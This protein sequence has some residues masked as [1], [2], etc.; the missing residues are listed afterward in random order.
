MSENVSLDFLINLKQSSQNVQQTRRVGGALEYLANMARKANDALFHTSNGEDAVREYVKASKKKDKETKESSAL[1]EWAAGVTNK[2]LNLTIGAVKTSVGWWAEHAGAMIS[3]RKEMGYTAEEVHQ[4]TLGASR[5][6][7]EFGTTMAS[8]RD[9]TFFM[10]RGAQRGTKAV[11]KLGT[12]LSTL[13]DYGGAGT[14][15]VKDFMTATTGLNRIMSEEEATHF[16]LALRA[17]ASEARVPVNEII[18]SMASLKNTYHAFTGDKRAAL[19]MIAEMEMVVGKTR[20]DAGLV[21]GY[22]QQASDSSSKLFQ[23][24]RSNQGDLMQALGTVFQQVDPLLDQVDA[25]GAQAEN[26]LIA[27]EKQMQRFGFSDITQLRGVMKG[28]EAL[29]SGQNTVHKNLRKSTQELQASITATLTPLEK[30]HQKVN[31][32]IATASTFWES[33]MGGTGGQLLMAALAQIEEAI[34]YL[35]ELYG[36][37]RTKT[38]PDR[39]DLAKEMATAERR[40]NMWTVEGAVD[41]TIRQIHGTPEEI[42]RR[43]TMDTKTANDVRAWRQG[44]MPQTFIPPVWAVQDQR[45]SDV[46]RLRAQ[47]EAGNVQAD[48]LLAQIAGLL[49]EGNEERSKQTKKMKEGAGTG[50]SNSGAAAMQSARGR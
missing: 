47:A 37:K 46:D 4:F 12:S 20:E 19:A 21:T 3:F 43:Q 27:L 15:T 40:F 45:P 38:K 9:L 29:V 5:A 49:K 44:S 31:Q 8:V 48:A 11:E 14:Q 23:M 41:K 24:I 13:T 39:A 42:E 34:K 18:D 16:L 17:A 50:V 32:V 26:A 2:A 1:M 7:A 25:G 22:F 28:Y 10:A 6:A 36:T 30:V 33:F 35:D